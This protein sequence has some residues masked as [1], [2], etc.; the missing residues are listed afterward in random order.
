MNQKMYYQTI[1]KIITAGHRITDRLNKLL[2]LSGT[3]EPQ[4]NVLQILSA[5]KEEALNLDE[6]Q[7]GMV[8]PNSNVSRI[9]DKLLARG[10]VTR[11]E[12]LENRRKKDI[13]LT[14]QGWDYLKDLNKVVAEFHTPMTGKLNDEE[15][16]TLKKLISKLMDEKS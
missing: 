16:F 8:Q 6:I 13:K 11:T 7:A 10:L 15:L 12:C 4:Y 3:T 1:H 2:K 14:E 9:V 5:A